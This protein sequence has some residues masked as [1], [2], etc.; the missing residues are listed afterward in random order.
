[1]AMAKFLDIGARSA[2]LLALL[3][4]A[5][6]GPGLPPFTDGTVTVTGGD[7]LYFRL[8]GRGPDTLLVL[9]GGPALSSGYLE[10]ALAPL[11]GR[12]AVLFYDQR[13]RGRSSPVSRLDSLSYTRDVADLEEVRA[14]FHLDSLTLI[15]HH[16]GA[17]LAFGYAVRHPER[18]KRL[19][20][21]SPMAHE[22]AFVYELALQPR[23]TIARARRLAALDHRADSLDPMGF[24]REFWGFGF[25]PAEVTSPGTVRRL[26]PVM[27]DVTPDRLR[28]R[29]A[30]QRRMLMTLGRWSWRDS[31][32]LL[33]RPTLVVLGSDSPAMTAGARMWARQ[34]PGA[35]LLQV[36]RTALFPWLEAGAD[37]SLALERFV[38]GAWPEGAVHPDQVQ[39]ASTGGPAP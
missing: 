22:A 17:G 21:L 30:L 35:Q 19:V 18:V 31:L 9:H 36:G 7:R 20:L 14:H 3:L 1:M 27:C 15:G 4:P 12:H 38:S 11:A 26:A 29:S 8:Y 33:T 23:D 6:A 13:G 16:W 39:A 32:A 5:C 10:E 25:S 2:L 28:Q 34:I 24:C 37:L